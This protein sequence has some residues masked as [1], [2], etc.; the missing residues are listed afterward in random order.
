MGRERPRAIG[1]PR[2]IGACFLKAGVSLCC[3]RRSFNAVG[4]A[5]SHALQHCR[6]S[7]SDA[8]AGFGAGCQRLRDDGVVGG[9]A[10]GPQGRERSFEADPG[11]A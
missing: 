6:L 3:D 7:T 5:C 9:R 2:D 10:A 1:R 8:A 4:I 11:G